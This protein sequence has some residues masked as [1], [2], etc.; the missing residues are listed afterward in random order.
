MRN[1]IVAGVFLTLSLGFVMAE[2]INGT[3]KKKDGRTLT[4]LV[5]K[6]GEEAVEKTFKVDPKVKVSKAGKFDKDA[7]KAGPAVPL[8]KGYD[9]EAVKVEAKGKFVTNDTTGLITEIILG[10]GKGGGKKKQ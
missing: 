9:D 3:I 4:I 5:T 2:N 1:L 7:G 8:E 6:K 10:G